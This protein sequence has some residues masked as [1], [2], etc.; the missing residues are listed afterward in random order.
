MIRE[1]SD[2]SIA[3]VLIVIGRDEL[4]LLNS[5]LEDRLNAYLKSIS[6]DR[7]RRLRF[8]IESESPE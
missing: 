3:K 5:L 1:R 2:G 4:V 6:P 7:I 8:W